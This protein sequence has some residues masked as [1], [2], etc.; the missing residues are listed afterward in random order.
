MKFF[1]IEE[2]GLEDGWYWVGLLVWMNMVS[3]IDIF[4]VNVVYQD[5]KWVIGG[6]LNY[7][8]LVNYWVWMIEVVYC[9][10]KI[11]E[12]FYDLDL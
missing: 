2:L 9:V 5:L 12:L 3:F 7:F 10:E 1:F 11:W 8:I 4:F 6:L